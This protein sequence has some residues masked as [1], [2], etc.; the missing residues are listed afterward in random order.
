MKNIPKNHTKNNIVKQR[1]FPCFT[2][3]AFKAFFEPF[4]C[5]S[6]VKSVYRSDRNEYTGKNPTKIYFERTGY[7][8]KLYIS[9]AAVS[10]ALMCFGADAAEHSLPL[11]DVNTDFKTY[12]D[13]RAITNKRSVQYDMQQE[14]YTDDYGIRCIGSDVCVALGTGYAESC[15]ERFEITLDS[16]NSFT[17][18]VGDIKADSHTDPTNRYVELWEGCG[19]MIEFIVDTNELDDEI[20]IMGSVGEYEQYSGNVTSIV[21]LEE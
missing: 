2:I 15:G 20:R 8:K 5:Q 21:R 3:F 16:G 18:V 7:M 14:A 9:A 19:D 1:I 13:Y 17:A 4:H 6:A 12:M 11:P 10:A